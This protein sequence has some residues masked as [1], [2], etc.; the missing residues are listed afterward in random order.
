[1]AAALTNLLNKVPALVNRHITPTITKSWQYAKVELRPPTPVEVV[2]SV[3]LAKKGFQN[4]LMD[5][6]WLEQPVKKVFQ[7]VLVAT[8]VTLWFF[9]GEVI[10]RKSLIG[11]N[12]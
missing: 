1:M 9:V 6:T 2:E 7:N 5:H 11:Y 12:V 3:P 10:G 8:E 4:A